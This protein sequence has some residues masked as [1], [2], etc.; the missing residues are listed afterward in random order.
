MTA[1]LHYKRGEEEREIA[2]ATLLTIG[3]TPPND[4]VVAHPKVSRNHAMIR[5]L[6]AGEYYLVDVGS[7]N[8]T[9]LNGKR[10]VIPSQ[11][12]DGDVISVEDCTLT[13]QGEPAPASRPAEEEEDAQ[14]TVTISSLDIE[15]VEIT[16]L[17]CD[18][19]N[20]TPISEAMAPNELAALMAKWFKMATKVIEGCSGTI[21]KFIGD[22]IMAAFGIPVSHADNEDRA[23]RCAIAMIRTLRDW[24]VRRATDGR[25]PVHIGIGLNTDVVVS[26]NIGSPKRMDYTVIGDGVNLAS[27]LESACKQYGARILISGNTY[28]RLRGT[29][30]IR[31]I[32]DVVVKG[33]TSFVRIYEVLDYHTDES[34]PHMMEVVGHFTEGRR[35]Y[36]NAKWPQAIRSFREVLRLHPGDTLSQL[37]VE[38][39]EH[40]KVH[41]PGD[42]WDGVWTMTSK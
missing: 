32:D 10:V 31:D 38:R 3:R 6:E 4:I 17:V 18:V 19:R 35:A 40:L 5:M 23:V 2:C 8:G 9:F 14:L 39:C 27:R 30:R 13:F 24:N 11:L 25:K 16:L 1:K 22:A 37:Y 15:M 21:D 33:K 36:G 7:T 41:P 28:A 12:K 34:F 20:Y 29:Y 42:G 26:G